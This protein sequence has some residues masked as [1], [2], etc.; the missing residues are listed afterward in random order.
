MRSHTSSDAPRRQDEDGDDDLVAPR[1]VG[2][3]VARP[4]NEPGRASG[5]VPADPK[6]SQSQPPSQA[7]RP[8]LEDLDQALATKDETML[9]KAKRRRLMPG[10]AV[11]GQQFRSMFEA[12]G[13]SIR[14]GLDTLQARAKTQKQIASHTPSKERQDYS[15]PRSRSSTQTHASTQALQHVESRDVRS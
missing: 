12:Y 3:D 14:R 9:V 7:V 4:P 6:A 1:L 11:S 15:Y 2:P 8:D 10:A 13:S 5:A